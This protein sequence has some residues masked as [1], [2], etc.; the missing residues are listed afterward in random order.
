MNELS[1]FSGA[2]A[3]GEGVFM[4][5]QKKV[6]RK[7]VDADHIWGSCGQYW[8]LFLECGHTG[9]SGGYTKCPKTS[10]CDECTKGIAKSQPII[11]LQLHGRS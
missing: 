8:E 9:W 6:R 5:S 1:L 7:V 3:G 11:R 2:G 10:I 4:A